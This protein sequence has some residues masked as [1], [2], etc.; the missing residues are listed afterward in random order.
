MIKILITLLTSNN[1]IA[2][3]Q[4]YNSIKNQKN[5]KLNYDLIIV[6]NTLNQNYI[7][8]V[9]KKFK[10]ITIIVTESNG[11]PGKGHN[12]VINLFKHLTQYDYLIPIDGDDFIYPEGLSR[13]EIYL[14][15]NPDILMLPYHD[16]LSIDKPNNNLCY[17]LGDSYYHFFNNYVDVKKTW[18]TTKI[19][20]FEN[21]I[22]KC[23]TPAR[24]ILLSR[25]GLNMNLKYNE[26]MRLYDDFVFFMQVLE[27]SVLSNSYNIFMID[28][29]NIYLYNKLS[30]DSVTNTYNNF[31]IKLIDEEEKFFRDS[32]YNKYLAIREWNL[33]KLIFLKADLEKDYNIKSKIIFS[34]NLLKNMNI[35]YDSNNKDNSLCL[36]FA[37]ENKINDL[38]QLYS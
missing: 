34:K 30:V 19:S 1:L 9:K 6:I 32:I 8:E 35:E 15:Y 14:E 12:S 23:N 17:H 10:N 13:L 29:N 20:P 21:N 24:L 18:I 4:S 3:E 16:I 25:N 36:R 7:E 33:N 2:L 22:N 27:Y 37:I 11:R 38:I 5:I 31:D 28:D 26:N